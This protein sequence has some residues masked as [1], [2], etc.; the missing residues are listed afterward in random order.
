MKSIK[1]LARSIRFR[2]LGMAVLG[3]VVFIVGLVG[4]E[5]LQNTPPPEYYSYLILTISMT[6]VAVSSIFVVK[7]KE[8]PR[9]GG[10]PSITGKWAVFW[11]VITLLISGVGI[12]FGLYEVVYSIFR[13]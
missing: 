11:G 8:M 13:K 12:F 9:T 1:A 7:Y 2:T 3:G 6:F 5:V 10:L 4:W